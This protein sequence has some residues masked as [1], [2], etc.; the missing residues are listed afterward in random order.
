MALYAQNRPRHAFLY[1]RSKTVDKDQGGWGKSRAHRG[2]NIVAPWTEGGHETRLAL[3]RN[4]KADRERQ[5]GITGTIGT[6]PSAREAPP[7][8]TFSPIRSPWLSPPPILFSHLIDLSISFGLCF[9]ST[10]WYR[11]IQACDF[12]YQS[13][14][15]S[16]L[17]LLSFIVDQH[18]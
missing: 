14:L 10:L 9:I 7:L 18:S 1:Q 5:D 13:F 8:C 11:G 2:G 15:F 6:P 17:S 3:C 4:R 12:Y 16:F